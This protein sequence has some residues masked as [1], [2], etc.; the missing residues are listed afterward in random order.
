MTNVEMVGISWENSPS[1][2]GVWNL[3]I[4]SEAENWWPANCQ[5]HEVL[6]HKSRIKK[7]NRQGKFKMDGLMLKIPSH[8]AVHGGFEAVWDTFSRGSFQVLY[9]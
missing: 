7:K 8:L 9:L 1:V 3:K 2:H 6:R 4:G 5:E